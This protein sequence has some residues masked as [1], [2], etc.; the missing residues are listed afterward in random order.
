VSATFYLSTASFRQRLLFKFINFWPP[1]L[2]AGIRL[3]HVSSDFTEAE[4]ELK[5]RFWN[6]NYVGVHFGGS[7]YAMTD[8]V[9]MLL[10][11]EQFRSRGWLKDYV[12]WDKA[13]AIRFKKP[14]RTNVRAKFKLTVDQ[15]S[16]FKRLTDEQG[17]YEVTL[18]ARIIGAEGELIAEV[19]K[20]LYFARKDRLKVRG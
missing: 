13:A 16:E 15:I 7:L 5:L 10:A 2:G 19:E 6:R 20:T 11:M 12:I 9:Y 14:G 3:K 17:R 8:P 4:V 1:F 18:P